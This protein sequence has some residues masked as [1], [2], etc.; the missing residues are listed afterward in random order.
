MKYAKKVV[1]KF[2]NQ[3]IIAYNIKGGNNFEVEIL[4]LGGIITRIITPDKDNNLENIVVAYKNIESYYK[5]PSYLGAIIGRTSG[6]IC[7]GKV[8]IEGK[9][10]DLNKNYGLH[11]GHG[12]NEGLSSKVFSV[13]VREEK[14]CITLILTTKLRD[15]E[16]NYPGN[17]QVEVVFKIY[18]NYKIEQIYK[19]KSDKTTL[20]NMTNHTY[21]N[22]S[23]D[24]KSPITDQYMKLNSSKIIEIDETCV[25]T[26]NLLNVKG[27]PFDFR[28]LKCIGDDIDENHSQIKIGCGYDHPFL[29]DENK[30]IYMEDKISKRN[31]TI[32]TN[33]K[34]VVIY[35]M[36]FTDDEILYNGKMNQRRFGICFETQ[37]PPIGRQMCFIEDSIL[38]KE[39]EY[40][41]KTVYK[42]D[43]SI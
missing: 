30:V 41:Q 6:R 15:N 18:E 19:G 12:G 3:D 22:L 11:Q 29:L 4:N 32:E 42:F 7:E 33:Q 17:L 21:F 5:N 26:G 10:Y 34:S 35:S 39:D 24:L 38:Q 14:D 16:E 2:K 1:G 20:V 43:L 31:M 23:G 8:N 25:P 9:E 36:N 27:T 37:A 13:D 28:N 40:M